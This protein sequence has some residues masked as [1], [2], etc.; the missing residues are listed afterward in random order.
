MNKKG[1][2]ELIV[3]LISLVI[4]LAI[5]IPFMKWCF[6]EGNLCHT[7]FKI[8]GDKP[9]SYVQ[10]S[11]HRL[12]DDIGHSSEISIIRIDDYDLVMIPE[13]KEKQTPSQGKCAQYP[14]LC[15]AKTIEEEGK[16]PYC[17]ILAK[18][19]EEWN[20]IPNLIG[21]C[22]I[23]ITYKEDDFITL[24]QEGECAKAEEYRHRK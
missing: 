21:Q 2:R 5:L 8:A 10:R 11:L 4:F 16:K 12:V 22:S 13:C 17:R 23:R 7:F 1:S 6:S 9:P 19:F 24:E 14:K 20:E 15:V 18:D 3:T